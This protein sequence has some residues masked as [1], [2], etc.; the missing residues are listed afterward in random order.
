MNSTTYKNKLIELINSVYM[1]EISSFNPANWL[2]LAS[3]QP[4]IGD[5]PFMRLAI[6]P[7]TFVNYHIDLIDGSLQVTYCI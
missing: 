1:T 7:S 5:V 3:P 6:F 2:I 4:M